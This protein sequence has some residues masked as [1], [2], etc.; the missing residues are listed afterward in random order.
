MNK[1]SLLVF[2]IIFIVGNNHKNYC[3]LFGTSD[4]TLVTF[5]NHIPWSEDIIEKWETK[6]MSPLETWMDTTSIK[7]INYKQQKKSLELSLEK[8]IATIQDPERKAQLVF[9]KSKI[10]QVYDYLNQT[11]IEKALSTERENYHTRYYL[12]P[13]ERTLL[14][15]K[16]F[17]VIA[18]P[19]ERKEVQVPAKGSIIQIY[20]FEDQ[21]AKEFFKRYGM[22]KYLSSDYSYRQGLNKVVYDAANKKKLAVEA[23]FPERPVQ[24]EYSRTGKKYEVEA[25]PSFPLTSFVGEDSRKLR[26]PLLTGSS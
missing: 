17:E 24:K 10:N 14:K 9:L 11:S 19:G 8:A 5:D 15:Q 23:I 4:S 6:I 18:Q 2:I 13:S 21:Q 1:K 20:L 3:P 22:N 7:G 12:I 26:E 16:Y 25:G